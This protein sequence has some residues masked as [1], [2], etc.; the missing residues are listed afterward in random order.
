M[1][2][3]WLIL[4][5]FIGGVLAWLLHG[6]SPVR[7]RGICLVALL[8]TFLIG[9]SV[10]LAPAAAT[11]AG[12]WV[13]EWNVPWITPFG[14]QFH[15]G[16]D[17]LSLLLIELTAFLG[18]V[19]VVA[20]SH[21]AR[22][23]T[24]G[25]YLTLMGVLAAMIGVLLALDLFLFYFFWE[26]MILPMA[27]WIAI[28]GNEG[29]TAAAVKFFLFTQL[30][31]LAML[32]AILGLYFAHGSATGHYTFNYFELLNTPLPWATAVWLMIGFF[33][34]FAVKLGIVPLHAW[35]PDAYA[36]S[37]VVGTLVLS[38]L[39][40]KT[41]AYG[42]LRFAIPLFPQAVPSMT[43]VA[44]VLA[45]I[46]ILY[47][48]VL[49]FAQTDIK[50]LI[51]YSSISHMGFVLLGIFA[52]NPVALDGVIILILSHAIA[53]GA[54]FLLAGAVESRLGTRQ[55]DRMGGLWQAA[56]R[57]GGTTMLFVLAAMG[58]PGLG[59]FVGEFLVLLGTF[60]V[61]IAFAVLAASGMITSVIYALWLLQQVFQGEPRGP[62]H[63]SD[64]GVREGWLYAMLAAAIVWL[65]IY[66]AP[67]LS[68]A[69][70]AV[71]ALD[72]TFHRRAAMPPNRPPD[73]LLAAFPSE[74][75]H[76]T[77]TEGP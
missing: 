30:S 6:Q 61:S 31:G 62:A 40:G 18:M 64:L 56:P 15:L 25:Y 32:L 9:L 50:R 73:A 35:L 26:L 28:W 34:A 68:A 41:A 4:V 8:A 75:T 37:P 19:A 11:T 36:E 33:V 39:M 10:W 27:L 2:L 63:V 13:A 46:S 60:R 58:L 77:Q 66:P 17:G 24:G 1:I 5:P 7:S 47:G 71:G 43:L 52:W 48:A 45:V 67:V 20:S 42:L 29:R 74:S 65:G 14:I 51:A 3:L 76:Q 54:L 44:M 57:L 69:R 21:E 22:Q 23:H 12:P 59:N 72:Q 55:L 53:T 70:P 38:A 49:A 16:A